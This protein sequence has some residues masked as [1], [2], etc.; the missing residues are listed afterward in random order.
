MHVRHLHALQSLSYPHH[1]EFERMANAQSVIVFVHVQSHH[2]YPTMANFERAND[3]AMG[4]SPA[5]Q[6]HPMCLSLCCLSLGTSDFCI[7][8]CNN[9]IKVYQRFFIHFELTGNTDVADLHFHY[10]I[11]RIRYYLNWVEVL[12]QRLWADIL[13]TQAIPIWEI[14]CPGDRFHATPSPDCP[15]TVASSRHCVHL[16][17]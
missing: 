15:K 8:K 3:E 16:F 7:N 6:C 4:I 1:W 11:H 17:S 13:P 5:D 10:S 2:I 14:L 9:W 12:A